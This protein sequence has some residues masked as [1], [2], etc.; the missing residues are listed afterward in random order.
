MQIECNDRID[1]NRKYWLRSGHKI[2]EEITIQR[3]PDKYREYQ[4]MFDRLAVEILIRE[5]IKEE[6]I[7]QVTEICRYIP[8]FKL[9]CNKEKETK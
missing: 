5:A 1:N 4:G 7:D 6:L 9:E 2:L 8:L 3:A